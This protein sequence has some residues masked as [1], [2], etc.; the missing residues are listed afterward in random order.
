[1]N[2][3][4]NINFAKSTN[5]PLMWVNPLKHGNLRIHG[6]HWI[7]TDGL[8]RRLPMDSFEEIERTCPKIN[9]LATNTSGGQIHFLTNSENLHIRVKL[10]SKVSIGLMTAAA[11][12]GFDC[13]V[14]TSYDDLKFYN[15]SKFD[16]ESIEYESM[17]FERQP[18]KKLVVV[19]FPLYAGV[20]ELLLGLD[21]RAWLVKPEGFDSHKK[22]VIYGTS[23]TQGG[24]A[25]RPGLSFPNILSRRMKRE[26]LNLGF[27]G[28]AFGE[29]EVARLVARIDNVQL[30]VLDYEANGGTNGK[31]ELT[32]KDFIETIR[33]KHPD[34]PIVVMS[35]IKYLFDDLNPNLNKRRGAIRIFQKN[36]VK[37]M[38]RNGD[39][40]I[41]FLDGSKL[42]GKDYHE[43]TVDGV[44][45]NDLGFM[46]IADG[47][48]KH[49][50][51]ILKNIGESHE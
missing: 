12:G 33:T 18:N 19:N 2:I 4:K 38:S 50:T 5:E 25:S 1:M 35:R 15:T 20:A 17:L 32:L 49:L 9:P 14:G 13:Y 30:F 10:T 11:Q 24:C 37:Q 31:L 44:H 21:S 26:F 36:V 42:T 22:I 6:F 29:I 28:N 3:D 43:Y 27:S 39:K 40:F 23:I 16:P 46:K 47:V 45:P 8:Y 41:F 51:K 48:E 7:E 34:T